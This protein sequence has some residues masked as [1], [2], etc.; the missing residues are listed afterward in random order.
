MKSWKRITLVV[1][2]LLGSTTFFGYWSFGQF[3]T[4]FDTLNASYLASTLSASSFHQ[5]VTKRDVSTTSPEIATPVASSTDVELSFTFPQEDE[6]VYISCTYHISWQSPTTIS[7]L[8][9]ALIDAG[10]REP[11]GPIASGLAKENTIEPDAQ[12][13]TW[14]VGVV[15]PGEYYIKISKINGVEA[16]FKSKV[17]EIN[18]MPEGS[19]EEDNNLCPEP[20]E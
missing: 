10:T 9:T 6:G 18:K 7:S 3:D 19:D 4:V 20:S 5:T 14:K 17:F 15:W 13:L 16:E 8:E 11:A 2:V 12:N 1:F